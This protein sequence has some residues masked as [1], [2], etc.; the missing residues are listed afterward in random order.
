M[1][2]TILLPS[3]NLRKWKIILINLPRWL[4]A[5]PGDGLL[6]WDHVARF[7]GTLGLAI[8]RSISQHFDVILFKS[9]FVVTGPIISHNA[10]LGG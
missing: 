6:I 5:G 8:S 2:Q 1:N 7:A 9:T 10:G 4:P 3:P